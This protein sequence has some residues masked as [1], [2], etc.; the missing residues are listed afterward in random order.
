MLN[1][2]QQNHYIGTTYYISP[3]IETNYKNL[4]NASSTFLWQ[5]ASLGPGLE[6]NLGQLFSSNVGNS[7]GIR[8]RPIFSFR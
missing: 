7:N 3:S 2:D 6:V 8:R 4:L 5:P 1:V